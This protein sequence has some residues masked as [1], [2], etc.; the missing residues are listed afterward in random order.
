[1]L[2]ER[3]LDQHPN[4]RTSLEGWLDYISERLTVENV[5]KNKVPIEFKPVGILFTEVFA[6]PGQNLNLYGSFGQSVMNNRPFLYFTSKGFYIQLVLFAKLFQCAELVHGTP[7]AVQAQFEQ[8]ACHMWESAQQIGNQ[9]MRRK[10]RVF[11][12]SCQS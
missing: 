12:I 10:R 6:F 7:E 9:H 3:T 5:S 2:V 1:M 8:Q 4:F 11:L